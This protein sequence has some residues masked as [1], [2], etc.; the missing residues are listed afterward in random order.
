MQEG[1][2]RGLCPR[3][4]PKVGSVTVGSVLQLHDEVVDHRHDVAAF[5]GASHK[6]RD[7][8]HPG[9]FAFE[10]LDPAGDQSRLPTAAFSRQEQNR[11]ISRK[12]I[13]S[14]K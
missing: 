12:S 7:H 8:Q 2:P 3:L 10:I 1:Q 11:L 6:I 4:A 13:Y 14:E 9:M 5:A